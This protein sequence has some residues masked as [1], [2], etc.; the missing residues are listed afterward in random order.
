MATMLALSDHESGIEWFAGWIGPLVALGARVSRYTARLSERQLIVAL[1]VPCR[2]FA[3]AL[4]GCGWVMNAPPPKL[5]S[6]IAVLLQLQPGTPVRIVT[7][8]EVLLDRFRSFERTPVASIVRLSGGRAWSVSRIR[9][10]SVAPEFDR[11]VRVPR[12]ALGSIGTLAPL[13]VTWD[14]RLARPAADLAIVGT[15]AWLREEIDADLTRQDDRPPAPCRISD[16]LLPLGP[17]VAT[18]STRLY[19]ASRFAGSLPLPSDVRTVILDGTGAIRY[20][21]EIEA[22]VVIGVIDRSVADDTAAETIVQLRNVRGEPLSVRD[23]L[24]W[25]PPLGVEALAFTV[26]L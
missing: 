10:I 4:I 24:R 17:R 15:E 18:W 2:N 7:E 6:P 25:T 22:Q 3:A 1:S 16:L 20:L 14:E 13:E 8:H 11:P 12:P 21:P 9:A 23:D 26:A 19:P 5:D